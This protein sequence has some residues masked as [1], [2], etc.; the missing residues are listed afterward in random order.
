VRRGTAPGHPAKDGAVNAT[1]RQELDGGLIAVERVD[2]YDLGQIV[3]ALDR[4]AVERD[5]LA[6]LEHALR[7]RLSEIAAAA[8][9]PAP[10]LTLKEVTRQLCVSRDWVHDH[11]EEEGLAVHLGG[12]VTRYDPEAVAR[13]RTRRRRREPPRD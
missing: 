10:L 1:Q 13:L 5:R 2:G 12:T 4:I 11:A 6:T 8:R 7:S 9:Q 3:H